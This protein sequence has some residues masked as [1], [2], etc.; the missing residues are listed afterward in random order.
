MLV[1][2]ADTHILECEHT[3]DFLE[4]DDK[5]FRPRWL[6]EGWELDGNFLLREDGDPT[7]SMAIKEM[8]GPAGR[9]AGWP[10]GRLKKMDEL[11]VDVQILLPGLFLTWMTDRPEVERALCG[12]YNRWMAEACHGQ[13]RFRWVLVPPVLDVENA[14]SEV[15]FG[16]KNGACGIL[17]RGIEGERQL[18]DPYFHPIFERA[19][20]LNLPIVVHTSNGN[21]YLCGLRLTNP[22]FWATGPVMAAFHILLQHRIPS[23]FPSLKFAFLETGAQWVPEAVRWQKRTGTVDVELTEALAANNFYVAVRTDNDLPYVA[24]YGR[25]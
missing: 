4:G 6:P 22:H 24:Q 3:W 25:E 5:H 18:S 21:R 19:Q 15:E 8:G 23:M 20:A 12:S 13:S 2:D 11:G 1:I 16:A 9:L 7:L 10:A 17:L 14:I